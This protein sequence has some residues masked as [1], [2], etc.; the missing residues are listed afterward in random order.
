MTTLAVDAIVSAANEKLSQGGG[1]CG[2]IHCA[3]GPELARACWLAGPCPT[4]DARTTPGF[5]G[6]KARGS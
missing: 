1:V 3:A 4:G 6:V 5:A 2:V